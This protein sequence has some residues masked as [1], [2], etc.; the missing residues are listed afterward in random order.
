[1]SCNLRNSF[2][3]LHPETN[4]FTL[5]MYGH[6]AAFMEQGYDYER[7]EDFLANKCANLF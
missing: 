2:R 1:M 3:L 5:G 7:S 6:M 4:L